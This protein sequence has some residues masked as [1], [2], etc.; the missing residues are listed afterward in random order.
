MKTAEIP[1]PFHG[2]WIHFVLTKGFSSQ[3]QEPKRFESPG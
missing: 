2:R 3:T 1:D